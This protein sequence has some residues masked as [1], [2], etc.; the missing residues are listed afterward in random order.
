MVNEQTT[1]LVQTATLSQDRLHA[2]YQIIQRMHSVYELPELLDFL[3]DQVLE[4][5]GGLRGYL[6]LAQEPTADDDPCLEVK[7]MRG[8]ELDQVQADADVLGWVS[9]SVVRDVLQKGEPRVIEDLRHDER[10]QASVGILSTYF[11]WQSI[12]AIPLKAAE[13]LIGLMYIEHPGRNAFPCPDLDFLHAFASQATVA[14]ARAQES[15]RRIQELERLSEVSQIGR[16]H[17]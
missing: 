11:K 15:Q 3:L 7:A 9:R 1:H 17:V 8:Q 5:T 13:R 6:L 16:A 12:L 14:I 2:L 10:Y 4:H